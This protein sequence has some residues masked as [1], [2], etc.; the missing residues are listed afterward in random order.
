MMYFMPALFASKAISS[1]L[2]FTGL[3][4][5][6]KSAPSVLMVWQGLESVEAVR[7]LAGTTKSREAE[8]GSIRGD[9]GMSMQQN[10][11]HAS[12][13]PENALR[14]IRHLEPNQSSYQTT[15]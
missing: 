6:M 14:E 15:Q 11:I 13:S 12:D 3:K 4:D 1:A 10:L 5:F 2:N 9:F 8:A 7:K